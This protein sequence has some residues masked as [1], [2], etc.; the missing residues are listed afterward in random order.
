MSVKFG[1]VYL[2]GANSY[3]FE[4]AVGV[5]PVVKNWV[6]TAARA[7]RIPVGV[8]LDLV[9]S[10]SSRRKEVTWRKLYCLEIGPGP[11]P[12][13][14]TLVVSDCRWLWS[15]FHV[16][17]G[18]NVRRTTGDKFFANNTT[19]IENAII[20]PELAYAKWSLYPPDNGGT[21]WTALQVLDTTFRAIEQAYRIEGTLPEVEVQDLELDDTGQ[22]AMDRVLARFPGADVYIDM[23]GTAVVFNTLPPPTVK[24][25]VRG[26]PPYPF[27]ARKHAIYPGDVQ[28]V[29]RRALR[30]KNVHVLVTPEVEI[31]ADFDEGGTRGRDELSLVNVCAV[32]DVSLTLTDGRTVARGTFVPLE[33]LF[34]AWG[35][36]GYFNRQMS[37]EILRKNALK[38]GWASFEQEFGN[39][40]LEP[41]DPV[42]QR[43]ASA[44]VDAWRRLYQLD[45]IFIQR[46]TGLRA[47]RVAI[48]NT[49]TAAYAP[50]EAYCDWTRRP[51]FKGYA[52]KPE[53]NMNH[54]WAVQGYAPLLADA[55]VAPARVTIEDASAGVF[56]VDPVVSPYGTVQ[57]QVWG[58]PAAVGSAPAG[59]LP[60]QDGLAR[61]NQQREDLYARWDCVELS[62]TFKLAVILTAN[63]AS[64][65]DIRKF[66]KVTISQS[67]AGESG[68]E[69]PDVYVRVFP[70]V[71]TAR[72]GWSDELGQQITD[73]IRGRAESLPPGALTNESLV[74]A[75]ALAT[76]K[77]TYANWRD[78]PL[79]SAQI[80]MDPEIH[81]QGSL[82]SVRHVMNGGVVATV[83]NFEGPKKPFDL[84]PFMDSGTR[85]V[86]LRYLG[87]A[88]SGGTS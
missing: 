54:G 15:R 75:V 40:P 23:D 86:L 52:G 46:L 3:E 11:T 58:Y 77:R 66:H 78:M 2:G 48:L 69:G 50:A 80:D 79:G 26:E 88:S 39:N 6:V 43:R 84:W 56:R 83:V 87:N 51:S 16:A 32:P 37:T 17:S 36:F 64:P 7:A 30:P 53:A 85:R 19:Q 57:A 13:Q 18:F 25:Q 4:Q 63:P 22:N 62:S 59:A 9:I 41:P 44:V 33:S 76:A 1:G 14:R 72:Y 42:N 55:K 8:P 24:T 73:A 74:R 67:E 38:H 29:S 35:A 68:A 5:S 34:S 60:Q 45:E 47:N 21:P 65:N 61:A 10:G 27:L 71:I 81:P 28:T 12:H 31:R 49:L 20:Q 70:G 82:A